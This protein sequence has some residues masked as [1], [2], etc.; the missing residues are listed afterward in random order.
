MTQI[1]NDIYNN[2]SYIDHN[3]GLHEEDSEYKFQQFAKYLDSVEIISN[4]IKILDIGGGAGILGNMVAEYFVNKG[5]EVDFAALDLSAQMLNV[6]KQNNK[7]IRMA[8]N[9]TI[10]QCPEN[11]F[12]LA[13]MIDV[14]EH[15]PD[16]D[17]AAAGLNGLS[18]YVI[19]NIP[20]QINLLDKLRNILNGFRYYIEQERIL[21][22]VHF[23]TFSSAI[24]FLKRHHTVISALFQ[25]YCF[26]MLSSLHPN[27]IEMRKSR[28]RLNEIKLSVWISKNFKKVS[29]W[30]VQGS[31]F[32]LVKTLKE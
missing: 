23:F 18:R 13:L 26:M 24:S 32:A 9:L 22:H 28:L 31:V 21:G 11:D 30:V 16:K 12:D 25:P 17:S 8:W 19:Y 15:I 1:D 29:P 5:V 6:Q 2:N 10:D 4:K 3:P 20:I 7:H 14:I 27:Y